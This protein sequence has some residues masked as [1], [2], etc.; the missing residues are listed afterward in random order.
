[1]TILDLWNLWAIKHGFI[2]V[3]RVSKE[4][5]HIILE[6]LG[7]HQDTDAYN[8]WNPWGYLQK[9]VEAGGDLERLNLK[10]NK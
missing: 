5:A 3:R 6:P 7:L 9:F 2:H 10:Q 4:D 8:L 1:M